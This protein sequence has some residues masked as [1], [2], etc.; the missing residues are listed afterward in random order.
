MSNDS[1]FSAIST[2]HSEILLV[3]AATGRLY[4]WS[5]KDGVINPQPHPLEEEL[6]LVNEKIVKISSCAVRASLV[7]ESG[8]VVTFY[9]SLLRGKLN[10]DIIYEYNM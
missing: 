4:T 3:G 10:I 2:L 7:T 6:G 1:R 9:D 8:G 5:C